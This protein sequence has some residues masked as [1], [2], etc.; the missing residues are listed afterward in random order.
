[1]AKKP[2]A[3]PAETSTELALFTALTPVTIVTDQA[4]AEELF[5]H[6]EQQIADFVPDLTTDTGRRAIASLAFRVTKT[7]TA[8][9]AA[10]EELIEAERKK[11]NDT[12]AER[13]R[14]ET[15]LDGLRDLARKPLTEWEER[16][17]KRK[18][19]VTE[20]EQFI[21]RSQHIGI[22]A[23]ADTVASTRAMLNG[24]EITA[25]LFGDDAERLEV[26]RKNAVEVLDSTIARL[27][28]Q[29]REKAELEQLRQEKAERDRKE[30]ERKEA[31]RQA[32]EAEAARQ[33]EA[34]EAQRRE[35]EERLAAEQEEER[36]RLEAEEEQRRIEAAAEAAQ[37]AERQRAAQALEDQRKAA[38]A[39]IAAANARAEEAERR[40]QQ[41]A[42]SQAFARA[43]EK[44]LA[45]EHAAEVK[46]RTE[47]Q[48]NRRKVKTDAKNAFMACG[49]DEQ[50]ARNIVLAILGGDV[51]NVT[52]NF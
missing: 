29:E 51:P 22:D 18:A 33:R 28:Q 30:A 17:E 44:R 10:A 23:T 25:E 48:E 8:I 16:E 39:E 6:I 42:E 20:A 50:T 31:E 12:V 27:E 43:E 49:A 19:L 37:L 52:L 4:K 21:E 5:T 14:I 24:T 3:A 9:T 40:A 34:E 36:K 11:V 41:E 1:M 26:L 47:D 15:K 45:D 46:A 35:D 2:A 13:R 38:E 32:Q 7:K